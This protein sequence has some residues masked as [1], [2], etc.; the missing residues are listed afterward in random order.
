MT[1]HT[2][3]AEAKAR[4]LELLDEVGGSQE[5]A[6][7]TRAGKP[8]VVLVDAAELDNLREHLHVLTPLENA[9]AL[10][11][12]LE[13]AGRGEGLRLTAEQLHALAEQAGR[14]SR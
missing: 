9:V 7:I 12:A 11:A 3:D 8:D 4:L 2:T 6:R 1:I 13:R 14:T 10:A 5:T